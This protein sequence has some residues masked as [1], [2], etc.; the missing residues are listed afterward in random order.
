MFKY[1]VN[2]IPLV[3]NYLVVGGG[4][5]GGYEGGGGGAGGFLTGSF[6]PTSSSGVYTVIVGIG[7]NNTQ[8]NGGNS[9]L[10]GGSISLNACGGGR[11]GWSCLYNNGYSVCYNPPS[12][13]GSGGG[14]GYLPQD[15]ACGIT[16][17]GNRGGS[18]CSNS[19][20]S[21]GGGGAGSVGGN[22]T[23]PIGENGGAGGN[24]GNGCYSSITGISRSYAGGGGGQGQYCQAGGG[25]IGGGGTGSYIYSGSLFQYPTPGAPNTGGGGGGGSGYISY[26]PVD[27]SGA[28][29]GSGIVVISYASSIIRA[30][31]GDTCAAYL[32]AG[33]CYQV[34]SFTSVGT[35]TF[36]RTS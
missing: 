34:H 15:G 4:G 21:G 6:N 9:C 14:A 28:C 10:V 13:G 11:G 12:I 31:G 25:G 26:V 36:R 24:G 22:P 1:I 18:S 19:G 23:L 32:S 16:G 7:G 8:T 29:G 3:L 17:Q 20:Y 33:T 35:S 27:L 5:A 30:T 2:N